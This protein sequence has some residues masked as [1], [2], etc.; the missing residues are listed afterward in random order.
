MQQEAFWLAEPEGPSARTQAHVAITG[1]LDA[2]ALEGALAKLVA[3]HEILRTT[4]VRQ[5]GIRVPLQLVNDA[6]APGWTT[7]ELTGAGPGEL[8]RRLEEIRAQELAAALDFEH[9]P[10]VR[11]VLISDG[12]DRHSL[13]LTV[14]GL[15]ADGPSV[16]LIA[17][18]LIAACAER[19]EPL[20]DPLQYADFAAWQRELAEGG[21]DEARSA[22]DFW[23]GWDGARSPELPFART[24]AGPFQPQEVIVD[25]GDDLAR[26]LRAQAARYDV[27]V[28]ALAQAAWHALLGRFSGEESVVVAYLASERRHA[29]L[30]GAVGVFSR[31]VPIRSDVR[32]AGTFA[33]LLQEVERAREQALVW[34][35]YAPAGGPGTELAIGFV[36]QNHVDA[37][38]GPLTASLQRLS[39][40]DPQ[41]RLWLSCLDGSEQ[42]SLVLA[43]DPDVLTAAHVERLAR[44]L[45]ELLR[46]VSADAGA[47]IGEL[48][49][50][51]AEQRGVVVEDFNA[52]AAPLPE[53]SVH[54][55][56]ARAAM[57]DPTR[58]AVID[59]HGALSYAELD[60]R[61]NQLA[62][63][64]HRGG[65]GPDVAVG[66]CTD[67]S[68]DMVVG[69]LGILKAGG[70][71]LPLHHEH[72]P[73]RLA[74]QLTTAGARAIVTQEPLL[75]GLPDFS[76]EIICLDR[77]R[78]DL[79]AEPT[80]APAARVALE[81]LV[82]VIYTSGSTGM[83]KG[84]G[85]T[86]ANLANYASYI[87]RR[88][89][90]DA[91]PL[92]FGVVTS[93]AT[94]L[95]NTAV[96][97]A[98]CSGGTLVLVSPIVAAD[99]GALAKQFAATPVDVLKITPSHVG[100]LLAG[101]DGAVLPRRWLIIGGERAPW[102]LVERVRSASSSVRLLNHYGPTEATVGCATYEIG[103]EPGP[104][105]PA[106]V[107]IGEPIGN[108]ACYVL[109]ADQ[110]PV[111]VGVRGRLYVAGAGVARG[112]VGAPEL[113]DERFLTDPLR[114]GRRM[115]DTGDLARWLPD[116]NLEFL[117]R[118]DEQIKIRG[119]RVEPAEVES[120][121][122]SHPD[123]R[124]AAVV[125]HTGAAGDARSVRL[126]RR[127]RRSRRARTARLPAAVAA[128]VHAA[129][130]DRDPGRA[131]ADPQRQDR[132]ARASRSGQP[133][134]R[135]RGLP[136]AAHP[137]GK[138]RG[139]DLVTR[140][141]RR[142][143]QRARRLLRARWSLAARHP[144][145]RARP[146]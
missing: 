106:S 102:D 35:D 86:H 131:A 31:L 116:G 146:Q 53:L 93:I 128:G 101:G 36:A 100:A 24:A 136:P 99:A 1:A 37:V 143:H 18:E 13:I 39:I 7:V 46:G 135:G 60:A 21:D 50:L 140:P 11:A 125:A 105:A 107:P 52:T 59:E 76:G 132:P 89:G 38:A 144:G 111:P 79:A 78:G 145:G 121:L 139:G 27:S 25:V 96:F 6:L 137:D 94:D 103:A 120:A 22:A 3:R 91:E 129:R 4:F 44:A 41:L 9:G 124:G 26:A 141:G 115:Y 126:L 84:V 32:L 61:A 98:L 64:L 112:Y 81:H 85:V 42:L 110:R 58:T 70:A 138:G 90:A 30:D 67:R 104:F 122:R 47:S 51:D 15:C 95:G 142:A 48:P 23:R 45:A 74:H 127:R 73:A 69:M 29:D 75:A 5:P 43:F 117:G 33:G 87:A 62:Q 28:S 10:L 17:A 20:E 65:I 118:I 97:G 19:P 2:T 77:D 14:S 66:L 71:Y 108:V 133:E 134:R 123:V 88:V 57:A 16:A 80:T 54:E 130:G 114:P 49:L 83:P 34:Q 40:C 92:R 113:T 8:S 72:P 56:F 109:D 119:Y 63:R 82:Y 55:L 12:N 68:V